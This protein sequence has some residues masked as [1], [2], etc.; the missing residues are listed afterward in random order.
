MNKHRITLDIDKLTRKYRTNVPRIIKAWKKG[1]NDL[2]ISLSL[3]VD[4]STL[5]QLKNDIETEHLRARYQR[6]LDKK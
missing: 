5:R 6:W 2:E 3:G 1:L 4:Y